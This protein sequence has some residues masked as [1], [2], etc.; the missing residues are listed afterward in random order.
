MEI[1]TDPAVLAAHGDD[2][3][4]VVRRSPRAVARPR[5]VADV[6]AAVRSG[7]PF[8]ARGY[9]HTSGGQAQLA[10]GLVLDMTGL[11]AVHEV[12]ADRVVVDAGCTWRSVLAAV[13]EYT[14]PVLTD[15]LGVS[16]GGTLSVGGIGGASH[17]CGLQT[18][19]VL[20]LDVVTPDGE[21]VHC[22]PDS[23]LFRRVLGGYGRAG[24]IVRATLPLVAAPSVVRR[25]VVPCGSVPELAARQRELVTD[26]RF[27]HVQGQVVAGPDGWLPLLEVGATDVEFAGGGDVVDLPYEAFADRLADGEVLLRET[28][29]W[30][31]PHPWWNAFLP[32]SRVDDFLRRLLDRLTPGTLG[33]SGLVLTYPIHTALVR[34]P[35]VRLPAEPVAWLVAVLRTCD[36]PDVL[37]DLLADNDHWYAE[38]ARVGGTVYPIGTLPAGSPEP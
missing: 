35:M 10:D 7:Q 32:D 16:V 4:H 3:G 29:E 31:R 28:G 37:P 5:A 22:P 18:D 8:V 34:T 14:P 21:L 13:P 17:R 26:G 20:A 30:L 12:A 15:Y 2:F 24:V 25:H 27:W 9:G 1:T 23:E 11:A 36:D 6:V 33:N 38:A 19:N